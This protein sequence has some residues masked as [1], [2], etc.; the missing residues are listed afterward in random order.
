[1]KSLIYTTAAVA[2]LACSAAPALA[3]QAD[4][5]YGNLGYSNFSNGPADNDAV[6]G[7]LGVNITPIIGVEG[8]LSE[9]VSVDHNVIAGAP[10]KTHLND[11]YAAYAVGR[12]PVMPHFDLFARVGYGHTDWHTSTPASSGTFGEDSVNYGGG[13]E[14][15]FDQANGVRAEYTRDDYTCGSCGAADVWSVGYVRRF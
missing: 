8:E 7:R 15:F 3:Q 6:T 10:T 12:L 2:V 14:Y 1:M 4:R 13:G 5:F 11:Q 9:G